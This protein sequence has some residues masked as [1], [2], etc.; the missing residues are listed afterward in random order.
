MVWNPSPEVAAARDF[1]KKFGQKM[2]IIYHFDDLGIMGYASWGENRKLC[3][4]AR[5]IADAMWNP[6]EDMATETA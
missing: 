1:G 4:R 5:A 2:V 3:D 6:G